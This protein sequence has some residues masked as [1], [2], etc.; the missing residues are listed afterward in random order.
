MLKKILFS[1]ASANIAYTLLN[2]S[3]CNPY[4]PSVNPPSSD[5]VTF[6]FVNAS[7]NTGITA[8]N[9]F[10]T[11][12]GTTGTTG[13]ARDFIQFDGSGQGSLFP[14][15]ITAPQPY[16]YKLSDLPLDGNNNPYAFVPSNLPLAAVYI[17]IDYGVTLQTGTGT[18]GAWYITPP[19]LVNTDA[20]IYHL[21]DTISFSTSP[22]LRFLGTDLQNS[23]GL[24]LAVLV[25][26]NGGN[27]NY[28]LG[29]PPTVP[30]DDGTSNSVFGA[31][32]NAVNAITNSEA[33]AQ[34]AHGATSFIAAGNA[35][36]TT[37]LHLISP[38]QLLAQGSFDRSYL[39]DATYGSDWFNEMF[40]PTT[41][42]YKPAGLTGLYMDVTALG[43]SFTT[44]HYTGNFPAGTLNFVSDSSA[45]G[46]VSVGP[47]VSQPFFSSAAQG[48]NSFAASGDLA[49]APFICQ[50]LSDGFVTGLFP[51]AFTQDNPMRDA[52]I[53][54]KYVSN[55]SLFWGG[56]SQV[57]PPTGG[58]WY[59]LY[60][61]VLHNLAPF[62]STNN[63]SNINPETADEPM[64]FNQAIPPLSASTTATVAIVLGNMLNSVIPNF[65]DTNQYKIH[66]APGAGVTAIYG[67][68][69][70]I[71]PGNQTFSEATSP[72]NLIIEYST[73]S[74][75]GLTYATQVYIHG[76]TSDRYQFAY[77]QP[78]API[79]P[80]FSSEAWTIGIG[81]P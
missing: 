61:A 57:P 52:Y 10:I 50:Y 36:A 79:L 59:N 69:H 47:T 60:A 65:T 67:S 45:G 31:Y 12:V 4:Y 58:P 21:Y 66:I 68:N 62:S 34:W 63:F 7:Q 76:P 42:F 72:I 32:V 38:T 41:G 13:A 51:T 2:A 1:G 27:A 20:N 78:P 8:G 73:G 43:P 30:R 24:P 80:S 46:A 56:S 49:V 53:Q 75:A 6:T 26:Y 35:G 70:I 3:T 55:P 39:F 22:H 40:D 5:F 77:P 54:K 28:Y 18:N 74:H 17:G 33:Q 71:G 25:T 14:A 9:I 44:Y 11:M 19:A 29:L 64:G 81:V 23:Y 37:Y 48:P 16:F 15:G